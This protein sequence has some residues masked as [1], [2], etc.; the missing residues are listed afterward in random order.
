MREQ[1]RLNRKQAVLSSIGFGC[2]VTEACRKANIGRTTFYNW[3]RDDDAFRDAVMHSEQLAIAAV[4]DALWAKAITGHP[5]A[6][7]FYL[8]NRVPERWKN[9]NRIETEQLHIV[10]TP[11]ERRERIA[12]LL[13]DPELID[14]TNH[15]T[16]Q[17][18]QQQ[19]T[20]EQ[21]QEQI[22][23]EEET[24]SKRKQ[25]NQRNKRSANASTKRSAATRSNRERADTKRDS[26]K[27]KRGSLS[28]SGS[29][30][31]LE[32]ENAGGIESY[33]A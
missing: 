5:T 15:A 16:Y 9:V 29:A 33:G 6:M 25:A 1:L 23:S 4:E 30:Y 8:C 13:A 28:D 18:N 7:I 22:S 26:S 24:A 21:A 10:I 12:E 19:S 27:R 32:A 20:S 17:S 2:T 14:I 3:L 31:D 11:E